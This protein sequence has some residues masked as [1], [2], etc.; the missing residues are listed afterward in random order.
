MRSLARFVGL[1]LISVN[2]IMAE[3]KGLPALQAYAAKLEGEKREAANFLIYYLP[4]RDRESLTVELFR[5]NL[6]QAFIAR[7]TY[8]WAKALPR[9]LFFNDVL[10]HAVVTEVRDPWRKRLRELF[11]PE[12]AAAK[13]LREACQAVS[14][15][16]P[17]LTGVE[18][19]TKRE[20]TCQS[21]A[22]SMRQG[23][24]SCTGL[25]ILM[26][27]ALRAVGIPARLAAI[28]LWG[29]KEGNHTWVEVH[30]GKDWRFTGFGSTPEQWDQGWE[31]PRCAYCDP[32]EPI[33]GVFATSYVPT[34]VGFPAVWEWRMAEGNYCEQERAEDGSLKRLVWSFQEVTIYG[35]DR[36]SHYIRLAGGRK[37][38]IPEGQA[39]VSVRV[40]LK[41]TTTRVDLPVRI[42]REDK[43][44]FEGRSASEA[45]DLN[46]YIRITAEPGE[47]VIEH[48][49]ANGEWQSRKVTAE[50]GKETEVKIEVTAEDAAGI[51]SLD[52]RRELAAWFRSGGAAWPDGLDEVKLADAGAVEQAKAELASIHR[53][54]HRHD[55]AA[56]ELGPL[57]QKL[58]EVMAAGGLKPGQ[59]SLGEHRMPFVLIRREKAA[60]PER[61]RALYY[62]MHGGGANP[63]AAGPH[64]WEVNDGEWQAQAGLAAKVYAGEGIYFVPRMADDRLG[65]WHH[66]H[67]QDAI[68]IVIEHAIREWGVDPDRVYL[69][70]ISEGCY[71]TQ[72]LAPQMADRFGGACAMAGG[73]SENMPLENLRNLAIRTEVGE[74]DTTF[75]R[76]GLARKYHARLEACGEKWGPYVHVLNVQAGRGHGIDYAPGPAWMIQ[77]RR[78]ARPQT[79]V[80]TA[81]PHEGRRRSAFYWLGLEKAAADARLEMV[82]RRDDGGIR[83]TAKA[84]EGDFPKETKIRVML[85]DSMADLGNPV[86]I[87][88][89]GRMREFPAPGRSVE[90]LARTLEE[91]GDP[92]FSFPAVI[93]IEP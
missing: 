84:V 11:H 12:V 74:K 7:E 90:S 48:R 25:S 61:G 17:A 42:R 49:E 14:A 8:P 60:V 32:M 57:P 87:E 86:A 93:E 79:V 34:P 65:R 72:I 50:V 82:A 66:A 77:H 88:V 91:R 21:P 69:L 39:C 75:D 67:H 33:H 43:V 83:L 64:A 92:R 38:P 89:N 1:F 23:M 44:V 71:G 52:Q 55:P 85:D 19:N 68:D 26:V 46:D 6:E 45:L 20:K 3:D 41:G 70:G 40:F 36:T 80:W 18:Y 81:V 29:T 53:E 2:A 4:E 35:I 73:I 58:E 28:P 27:D 76:V 63:Q 62:A 78:D 16:L 54:A 51:F 31:I 9:E 22:E 5:E 10:P 56:K 59:L 24:A 13:T 30:D 15:K 37:L 47:F